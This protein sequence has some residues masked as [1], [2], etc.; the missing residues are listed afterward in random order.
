MNKGHTNNEIEQIYHQNTTEKPPKNLDDLI[1]TQA[2]KTCLPKQKNNKKWLFSL[3]TAAVL[4][5][6]FS[7]LINIQ[8][9]HTAVKPVLQK[10]SPTDAI[11][12]KPI[13]PNA[14]DPL[15]EVSGQEQPSDIDTELNYSTPSKPIAP[16]KQQNFS[17]ESSLEPVA[18]FDMIQNNLEE[19]K[20]MGHEST[21]TLSSPQTLSEQQDSNKEIKRTASQLSKSRLNDTVINHNELPT[22]L[23]QLNLLINNNQKKRALSLLDQLMKDHPDHDFSDYRALL[24]SQ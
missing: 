10:K 21:Q 19:Q 5:L 24:S 17:S 11:H 9:D 2:Q 8:Y 20:T 6:S 18:E 22:K 3:S 14:H 15:S 7:L 16:I 23:S 12:S 4:F 13:A 1:M